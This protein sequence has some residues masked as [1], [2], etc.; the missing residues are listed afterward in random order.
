MQIT[1]PA[2]VEGYSPGVNR[3]APIPKD[4]TPIPKDE[5]QTI[6]RLLDERKDEFDAQNAADRRE[7]ACF[8]LLV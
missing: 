7:S 4:E 6:P 8:E 3:M 1:E 2:I 5:T